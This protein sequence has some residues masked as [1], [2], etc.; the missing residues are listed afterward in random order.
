[1]H[2]SPS[3]RN[4]PLTPS[5]SSPASI[6]WYLD[7]LVLSSRYQE[8]LPC[9][10]F[11]KCGSRKHLDSLNSQNWFFVT[12]GLDNFRKGYPRGL[13]LITRGLEE[14]FL[15][16]LAPKKRQNL[17]PK[18]TT[19]LPRVPAIQQEPKSLF[20]HVEAQLRQHLLALYVNVEED[21]PGEL[22][23]KVLEVLDPDRKLEDSWASCQDISQRRKEPT[24]VSKQDSI[25][26]N[27]E[28]TEKTSVFHS[29]QWLYKEKTNEMDLLQED[30]PLLPEKIRKGVSD[31]CNWANTFGGLNIDE[32]FILKQFD[33]D[34]QNE[35]S[36][37]VC[38]MTTL[39]QVPLMLRKNVGLNK[40]QKPKF[41][42]KPDSEPKSQN[43]CKSKWIKM[44]YGAWY[45]NTKLWRKHRADES[46]IDLKVLRKAQDENVKKELQKEEKLLGDLHGTVAFKEFIQSRGFRMPKFLEKVEIRKGS[47]KCNKTPLK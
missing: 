19:A 32:E 15:P 14:G 9:R 3:D 42:Q 37:D 13:S 25:L 28:N 46:L 6:L 2:T 21:M 44:N 1:M 34:Y 43:I 4:S 8:S 33:V 11:T 31:F 5:S 27:P 20:T 10:S 26:I 40:M 23:L 17:Q 30:R 35:T 7:M 39:N 41:C 36:S 45:L 24:K 18:E 38:H 16:Q 29:G 47:K 22:L 12:R